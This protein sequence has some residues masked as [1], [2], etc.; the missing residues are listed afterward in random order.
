MIRVFPRITK[1]TPRDENT[2]FG[3]PELFIPETNEVH[4]SV[5]FS[6]DLPKAE[7]LAYQ[8]E[9]IAPVKLGGP[10]YNQPGD[11]FEPGRYLKPG[12]VITSRGCP[13]HCWFCSVWKREPKLRELEIKDG[14][15]VLDDNLLACSENHIRSVFAMLK[16]QKERAQ[17]TGG[18]EAARLKDWHVDLF[19]NLKPKQIFFAYDTSDD[20]EPLVIAADK[21]QQAGFTRNQLRCYTLI[22]YRGDTLAKAEKRLWDIVDIGMFPA[23]MLYR[24]KSGKRDLDWIKFQKPWMRP[25]SIYAKQAQRK[26]KQQLAR[27]IG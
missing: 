25:A 6:W 17:F 27:G 11:E 22:G 15:N 3:P 20:W 10:A 19:E 13:N 26:T 16:Q 1:A 5:A 24:D 4:I 9:K 2:F 23:A 7:W 18:I 14:W 12:Y 8:W 21:M